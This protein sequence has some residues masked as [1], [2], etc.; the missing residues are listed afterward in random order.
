MPTIKTLLD[1]ISIG[2]LALP[3][4]Q[5]GYVW[6]R[7]QV[8]D[9]M[10][11]LYKGYP[12]G[13]LLTWQTRAENADIRADGGG[14]ESGPIELLLDGQQRVTSLYGLIRGTPP[15]FF[16]GDKQVITGMH[17]HLEAEEFGYP[18]AT[19]VGS[20]PR[21]IAIDEIFTPNKWMQG[22]M[23]GDYTAEQHLA[24]IQTIVRVQNIQEADMPSQSLTGEDKTPDVV[25]DI[26]NKVNSGGT[27]LTWA[28]LTLA[29]ICAQWPECRD[30]MKARI[31]KWE[32][33]GFTATLDWLLRAMI[34]VVYNNP[35][36]NEIHKID[37]LALKDGLLKAERAIDCLLET[38]RT[39][40]FIDN[41]KLYKNKVGLH[42]LIKY[43]SDNN[44]R[45][46]DQ[47]I[48]FQ[49]LHWY[50]TRTIWGFFTGA[51]DTK[52]ASELSAFSETDLL[53][54]LRHNLRQTG[55]DTVP[56]AE[57][58]DQLYYQ[59]RFY[60]LLYIISRVHDARD[61][62]TGNRLRHFSLGDGTNLEM[63]HIFPKAYL[64][65]HNV[66]AKEINNIGNIAF[67]TG[68]TNRALGRRPPHEYMPE[69]QARWPG[70][71]ESQWIPTNPALWR[72]EKYQ[73]FLAARRELLAASAANLLES[74]KSGELPEQD[75]ASSV[76]AAVPATP[77][78]ADYGSIDT[79]DELEMLNALNDYAVENEL[80]P[81]E[82]AYELVHPTTEDIVAILD[83]AWPQG[84]QTG[85]SSPVAVLIEEEADVMIATQS[86][87]YR[88]FTS[89]D[90]FK[91]YIDSEI[92]NQIPV[93]AA[94]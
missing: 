45:F 91:A 82:I 55:H 60:T 44:G 41:D 84:L 6:K 13:S 43:I 64:K 23:D 21:W 14:I 16:D 80:P 66:P 35:V 30:E 24:Y 32:A 51:T 39:Y 38:F 29:R 61:W 11:S 89:S 18:S 62:G 77:M 52:L 5:R 88:V 57:N 68:E 78:F 74:L 19:R 10:N 58:F 54:T 92:I 65:E 17:F 25:V 7:P 20:D 70:A 56:K 85:F 76:V 28:D 71:L 53:E 42:L 34:V 73:E 72:V 12:V 75:V 50:L 86:A 1:N 22:L 47:F 63:H 8:I 40:L 79:D 26:F 90:A 31:A 4:F 69:V 2:S 83:L 94:D 33:A 3:A 49:L 81:G 27:N 48:M 93:I 59:S 46:P 87:G 67:Q 15:P 9:L 37:I 36:F